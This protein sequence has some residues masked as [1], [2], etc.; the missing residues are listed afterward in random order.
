[1]SGVQSVWR[2]LTLL[3]FITTFLSISGKQLLPFHKKM[4][5]LRTC[6]CVASVSLLLIYG[7]RKLNQAAYWERARVLFQTLLLRVLLPS[8]PYPFPV[9]AS[10]AGYICYFCLVTPFRQRRCYITLD[11]CPSVAPFLT[12]NIFSCE[13]P[14]EKGSFFHINGDLFFIICEI[15]CYIKALGT[16]QETLPVGRV[17][18]P[19][20]IYH[21]FYPREREIRARED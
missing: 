16:H 10:N 12:R 3:E 20:L 8:D 7:L 1:M 14:L 11:R 2:I 13:R 19:M 17:N 21:I 6:V 4:S 15:S 9:Y 18:P 5:G